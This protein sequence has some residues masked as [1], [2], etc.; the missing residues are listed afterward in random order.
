MASSP[1]VLIVE[2]EKEDRQPLGTVKELNT[3]ILSLGE[4]L[5]FQEL[6]RRMRTTRAMLRSRLET[7]PQADLHQLQALIQAYGYLERQ[8]KMEAGRVFEEPREAFEAEQVEYDRIARAL[9]V[10]GRAN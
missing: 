9:E 8:L 10:V 4:H 1:K 6:L 2:I 5:G 3:A 7:D